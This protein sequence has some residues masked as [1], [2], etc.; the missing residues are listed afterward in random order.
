MEN[1]EAKALPMHGA[2][3]VNNG[4]SYEAAALAGLGIVQAPAHTMR[5]LIEAGG[6]VEILPG[7]QPPAM[8]VTLLYAQRRN[9]PLRVRA[10]MDW[11]TALLTPSM[12]KPVNP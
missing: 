4:Q 3:T 9:L 11:V 8:P 7:L 12:V 2:V 1:G 10:F 5:A 6:L